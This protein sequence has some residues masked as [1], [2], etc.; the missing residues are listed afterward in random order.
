VLEKEDLSAVEIEWRSA[1][2]LPARETL[3]VFPA[4]WSFSRL[5]V[6]C[7]TVVEYSPHSPHDWMLCPTI[8][9]D[10]PEEG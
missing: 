10:P 4:G 8:L 3:M 9:I 7:L 2:E 1:Q 6:H 5:L